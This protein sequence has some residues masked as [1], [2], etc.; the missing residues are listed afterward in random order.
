MATIIPHERLAGLGE[1]IMVGFVIGR[2]ELVVV[3]ELEANGSVT[4]QPE[5][6]VVVELVVV[7]VVTGQSELV[8]VVEFEVQRLANSIISKRGGALPYRASSSKV[9]PSPRLRSPVMRGV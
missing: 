7:G 2:S 4:G 6:V 1:L 9:H 3:V 8:V 5:L